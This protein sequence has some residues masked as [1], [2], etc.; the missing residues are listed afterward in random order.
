MKKLPDL[1]GAK[2]CWGTSLVRWCNHATLFIR[3]PP[4]LTKWSPDCAPN[5]FLRGGAG[6]PI[7]AHRGRSLVVSF[8]S[9]SPVALAISRPNSLYFGSADHRE[10]R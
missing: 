8:H 6:T 2:P 7:R 4:W 1:R 5:G 10:D 3:A 9:H